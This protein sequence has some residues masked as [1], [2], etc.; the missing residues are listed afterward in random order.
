MSSDPV[1]IQRA[2]YAATAKK[3][4]DMHGHDRSEHGF[5]LRFM[6]SALEHLEIRSVL[7]VGC[8]TGRS[9]RGR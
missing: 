9:I 1:G 5:A 2:Y 8:G 6:V 4:D 7:D 3:Y